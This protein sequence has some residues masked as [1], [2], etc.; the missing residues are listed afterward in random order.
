MKRT[1]ATLQVA[2]TYIGTVVGAGF[3]TGQ[4]ILQFFT[5]YGSV[6]LLT[7]LV[8][9]GLFIWFGTK[10]MLIAHDIRATSYEDLN[11]HL[12]GAKW[13]ERFSLFMLVELFSVAIVMLAGAGSVFREQLGQSF[14]LGITVTLLLGYVVISGGMKGIMAVNS[15]VV[16]MMLLFTGIVF[17]QTMHGAEFLT[18]GWLHQGDPY[19]PG[20][21]WIAPMLYAAF[22]LASAQAVLVPLG[23]A[24]RDR[25]AIQ[26]GGVLG[27]VGLGA[28]LLVGHISLA[29]YAP[30]IFQYEIPMGLVVA[31]MGTVIH[32]LYLLLIYAEI[33]TT[34]IANV[35]GLSLQVEQR[36]RAKRQ[37]IVVGALLLC[38]AISF[39][40]FKALLSTLYP[41]FGAL[42]LAWF[43]MVVAR[44]RR[45]V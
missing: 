18:F 27:G 19:P 13:G 2:F 36:L 20:R 6:A 30:D 32:F 12:F 29:T 23:A 38:F 10:V 31:G 5:K 33:F 11:K 15:V 37:T 25:R 42:S 1:A 3:A 34:F 41:L 16:P 17:Y 8:S 4:E 43:A 14:L 21:A 26:L 45:S 40:G 7:I 39:V 24:V 44:G 35:F 28:L 9:T 22:N